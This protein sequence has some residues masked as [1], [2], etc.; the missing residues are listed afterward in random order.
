[1]LIFTGGVETL[2]GL[3]Q[4]PLVHRHELGIVVADS[5]QPSWVILRRV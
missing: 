4:L 3:V 2:S 1:M 5:L